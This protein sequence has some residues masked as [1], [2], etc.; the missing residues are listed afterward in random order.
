MGFVNWAFIT[1]PMAAKFNADDSPIKYIP[2]GNLATRTGHTFNNENYNRM[3]DYDQITRNSIISILNKNI[4]KLTH[5][6]AVLDISNIK[7]DTKDIAINENGYNVKGRTVT[8]TAFSIKQFDAQ[9][10]SK[11]ILIN[12]SFTSKIK[13]G[14][15]GFM[16]IA[17]ECSDD[18]VRYSK[19][20][21][22]RVH[23]KKLIQESQRLQQKM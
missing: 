7:I 6:T 3:R 18:L 23:S 14:A 13:K 1:N 8:Y 17:L 5:G 10:Y 21:C 2:I 22:L 15:A 9:G 12:G 4:L 20:E 11:T 16:V 19:T